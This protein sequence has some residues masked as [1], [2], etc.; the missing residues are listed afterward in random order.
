[1]SYSN[2]EKIWQTIKNTEIHKVD[3][4]DVD[5]VVSVAVY[6]YPHYVVSIWAYVG[7]VYTKP[8]KTF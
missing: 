7:V 4:N 2:L 3:S 8:H 6:P 1:M 5:Y